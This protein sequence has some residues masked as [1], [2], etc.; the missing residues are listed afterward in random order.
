MLYKKL[1]NNTRCATTTFINALT[2]ASGSLILCVALFI[3]ALI[4]GLGVYFYYDKQSTNNRTAGRNRGDSEVAAD[5]YGRL[6]ARLIASRVL[7]FLDSNNTPQTTVSYYTCTKGTT[8]NCTVNKAAELINREDIVLTYRKDAA[9]NRNPQSDTYADATTNYVEQ[10][11]Q[12]SFIYYCYTNVIAFADAWQ[13]TGNI[14]YKTIVQNIPNDKYDITLARS[15]E[16]GHGLRL[17]ALYTMTGDNKFR[18]LLIS[19]ADQILAGKLRSDSENLA[20]YK[21]DNTTVY[22]KDLY[23]LWTHIIPAFEITNNNKYLQF[24]K[25]MIDKSAYERN[26]HNLPNEITSYTSVIVLDTLLK[27]AQLDKQ[28]SEEYYRKAGVLAQYIIIKYLDTPESKK[29]I[30]D[31]GL[32]SSTGRPEVWKSTAQSAH[33]ARLLLDLGDTKLLLTN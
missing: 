25:T 22:E 18:T 32:I 12:S 17:K 29:Y 13:R 8:P 24:A 7:S 26:T 20:L 33:F 2:S 11:C 9:I 27:L 1:P 31:N 21:V 6:P 28:N 30:G 4:I 5:K 10:K 14:K 15:I 3:V 23:A 19:Q 16:T